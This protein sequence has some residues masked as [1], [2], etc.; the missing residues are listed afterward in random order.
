MK[1]Y[2]KSKNMLVI[3][4]ELIIIALGIIGITFATAKLLN[5]RTATLI[6][7]SEYNLDYVGD[8]YIT[9]DNMEPIADEL[10]NYNTNDKVM[11]LSFSVRGVKSNNDDKLI[12][13]V[14]LNEMD[15]D[16]ALLN[17]YTKWNLYKNGKLI[18]NGSLDPLF[19]G[20]VLSDSMRL[21]NVQENLPRYDK[22]Y[23]N[24][25]LI[26]WIS[27]SCND[28]ETCEVVDQSNIL[29]SKMSM[30]VFIALYSGA[31]K[32]YERIP[33]YD[34]T[35]ANK[36]ELYDN[37]IPVKYNDGQW[38]VAD[39]TNSNY[40]NLWYSYS[41]QKWANAIV[42]NDSNKY[43]NI[44]MAID[45]DDVLGHFVWIPRFRYKLWN[46]SE[47]IMDSYQ[48]YDNGISIVFE[49][50]LNSVN[51]DKQNDKYLTHP[52]FGSNLRGF[53]ISKYEIS[54]N[55]DIYKFVSG[56][57]SYRNDTLENY[58]MIG[59]AINENY[60]LGN[61][62]ESHMVNNLEWGATLYLSHSEYGVCIGDG[63]SKIGVNNTY[64]S[65]NNKQDT[66]TRNVYGVY[67]MAG[68]SGEYVLGISE[69]GTAT[70]EVKLLDN[71]TWY[72]G[73]GRISYRDYLIRGGLDKELFYF[74][75]I[76]MDTTQNATRVSLISKQGD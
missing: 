55:N 16:C 11:R 4:F 51:D 44:G 42:V 21:T 27:E 23:D 58:Q 18:S 14:M 69:L 30:K 57:E 49:N 73:M 63:C 43:K 52:A 15:I 8:S 61:K 38:V 26:F 54:N 66:T 35:C 40:N 48:A 12:Y 24:Y 41:D 70:S 74:G 6:T 20:D 64:I 60:Q 22:D 39:E 7:A 47:E 19:D 72:N 67:D 33:N 1:D 65:G 25:V 9:I 56:V 17:K 37:M 68:A 76:G 34:G 28:I 53:W 3:I 5:D 45:D 29:N 10:V 62:S 59:K 75:D 13:D 46:A 2:I 50:G 71:N 36:P 32:R 31:K